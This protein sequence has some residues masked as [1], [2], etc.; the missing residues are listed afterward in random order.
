MD[1]LCKARIDFLSAQSR[2]TTSTPHAL[3]VQTR[4][5]CASRWDFAAWLAAVRRKSRA[6]TQLKCGS[7]HKLIIIGTPTFIR[8]RQ[9]RHPCCFSPSLSSIIGRAASPRLGVIIL[10]IN[11]IHIEATRATPSTNPCRP[12]SQDHREE[13]QA[14]GGSPRGA[15]GLG[16]ESAFRRRHGLACLD[17]DG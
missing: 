14:V 17:T 16:A 11:A 13:S 6:E 5:G 10:S 12:R 8:E 9:E 1:A 7:F 15:H 2:K 3:H 4:R